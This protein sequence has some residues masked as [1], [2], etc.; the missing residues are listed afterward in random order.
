MEPH[1]FVPPL[2]GSVHLVRDPQSPRNSGFEVPPQSKPH[3]PS[4]PT[5]LLSSATLHMT[6]VEGRKWGLRTGVRVPASS[7]AHVCL[8]CLF[9]LHRSGKQVRDAP[10]SLSWSFVFCCLRVNWWQQISSP[11]LPIPLEGAERLTRPL[12]RMHAGGGEGL[13]PGYTRAR[14]SGGRRR[15]QRS[16]M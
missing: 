9:P 4:H 12:T 14:E 15:Q 13:V 5:I 10:S 2:S 11:W 6:D 8:S 7:N 1:E 3:Q 16:L